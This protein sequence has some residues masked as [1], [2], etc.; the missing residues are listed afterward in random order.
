MTA[1]LSPLLRPKDQA[2]WRTWLAKHHATHRGGFL[3]LAKK[4]LLEQRPT[5]LT[6]EQALDEALCFGWIDGLVKYFDADWRAVRFTPRRDDSIWSERNKQRVARLIREKKM[7]P[8]G[9]R[10]VEV[11]KRSGEWAAAR[12]R[13]LVVAPTE[14]EHAL[15]ED[16]AAHAFW[17]SLAPSHRKQWIFWVTEAKRPETKAR[18]I[19]AVVRECASS[20]RPG[21][22]TPSTR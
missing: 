15:R 13:E 18:R 2:A 10:L 9:Q 1:P 19:A 12:R 4:H 20:R 3:L 22:K 21:M 14:L 5:L 6:Y 7:T 8:A 11:A 17:A 16:G